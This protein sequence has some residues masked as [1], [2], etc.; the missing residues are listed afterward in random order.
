M[1]VRRVRRRRPTVVD[2]GST[3]GTLVNTAA[4]TGPRRLAAGDVIAL[5]PVAQVLKPDVLTRTYGTQVVLADG[6][7]VALT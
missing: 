1:V 3:N 2:L 4:I 6:T 5:G 7:R